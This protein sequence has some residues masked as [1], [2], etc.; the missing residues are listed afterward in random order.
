MSV[1]IW[2]LAGGLV[3]GLASSFMRADV[4]QRRALNVCVGMIGA[5]LAGWLG[6]PLAGMDEVE[7]ARLG[8]PA[9]VLA[10]LLGAALLLAAVT[11]VRR[12]GVR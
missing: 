6:A 11:A 3:G 9:L 10:P 12:R 1:V 2:L 8:L 5:L 4:Q 7:A